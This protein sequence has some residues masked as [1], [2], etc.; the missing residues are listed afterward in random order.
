MVLVGKQ[1]N[2]WVA[3]IA[4]DHLCFFKRFSPTKILGRWQSLGSVTFLSDM[5]VEKETRS[6]GR[7]H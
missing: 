4:M 2:V 3:G 5:L 6:H 1:K 7:N